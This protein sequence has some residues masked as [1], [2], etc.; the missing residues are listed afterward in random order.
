MVHPEQDMA[1]SEDDSFAR[2]APFSQ[3][4][5]SSEDPSWCKLLAWSSVATQRVAHP[6]LVC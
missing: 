3:V 1:G 6:V 5:S 2:S 4:P